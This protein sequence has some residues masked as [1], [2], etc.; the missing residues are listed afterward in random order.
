MSTFDDRRPVTGGRHYRDADLADSR[1]GGHTDY[2]DPGGYEDPGGHDV[3]RGYAARTGYTDP[4]SYGR[5]AIVTDP[6]EPTRTIPRR[7]EAEPAYYDDEYTEAELAAR[8]TG[9][10]GLDED[11][12]EYTA[13][14]RWHAGADLGLLILRLVLAGI[15][16][17]HGAQKMFGLFDG[18]GLTGFAEYLAGQ[19]YQQ[20][21]ILAYVAGATE[22]ASGVLLF[23]GLF[24][25]L[26][27]AGALGMMINAVVFKWGSGFFAAAG[28]FEFEVV[29]AGAALGLMFA[30]PGRVALDNGRFW[31]RR[32]LLAGFLSLILAVAAAAVVVVVFRG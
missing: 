16:L 26:A 7:P 27:A 24:T 9:P 30:G 6:V 3:P 21:R 15:F 28:G 5:H 19:G 14:Q 22:L 25:S 29:L 2:A 20:T 8:E 1:V 4:G 10:S 17:L 23:F 11:D 32:P 12:D 18:P 13:P 31:T